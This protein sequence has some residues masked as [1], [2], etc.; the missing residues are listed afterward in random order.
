MK[1]GDLNNK[2][3]KVLTYI[4]IY[5]F[6]RTFI[7]IKGN[8]HM[9]K[10]YDNEIDKGEKIDKKS[11]AILGCGNHAFTD[12]AYY[13]KRNIGKIIGFSMDIDKNK[14]MSL[15][16]EYEA[17]NYTTDITDVINDD[18]IKLIYIVSNHVTH[19]PYAIQALSANKDVFIEKPIAINIGQY[20]D[21]VKN[22]RAS[23][24]YVYAGYNRP[25]SSA[26]ELI[27]PYVN[28]SSITLNCFVLG[29][30][31]PSDHWYRKSSEGSRI[32]G[33]LGHWIDLSTHLMMARETL[34]TTF[35]ISFLT[36]NDLHKD[37]DLVVTIKSNLNDLVVLTFS[38]RCDPFEGVM[39]NISFQNEKIIASIVDFKKITIW[40]G[41]KKSTK[42]FLNKDAGHEKSVMQPFSKTKRDWKELEWSTFIMLKIEEMLQNSIATVSFDINDEINNLMKN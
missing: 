33:N 35:E 39:E 30:K 7:K 4:F 3:N 38:T 2:V 14:A 22:V 36:A 6:S 19:T 31:L 37:D 13:L 40:D 25:F 28:D 10:V 27:K 34:P 11:V 16:D 41:S 15:A 32:V 8:Y 24:N 5:G 20:I 42:K 17:Y 29:H 23:N 21:L 9:S 12:I 1:L 18:N 26:I